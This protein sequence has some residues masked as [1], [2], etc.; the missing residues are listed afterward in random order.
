MV[1]VMPVALWCRRAELSHGSLVPPLCAEHSESMKCGSM[2]MWPG[3]AT[4]SMRMAACVGVWLLANAPAETCLVSELGVGWMDWSRTTS[5][6]TKW[7]YEKLPPNLK[8]SLPNGW[9]RFHT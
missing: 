6:P 3:L 4:M 2:Q 7:V 1:P 8:E 5:L 9:R